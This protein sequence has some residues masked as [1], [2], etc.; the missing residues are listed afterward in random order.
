M[1]EFTIGV[2]CGAA[3]IVFV[4]ILCIIVGGEND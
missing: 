1:E 3:L 4:D 2:L